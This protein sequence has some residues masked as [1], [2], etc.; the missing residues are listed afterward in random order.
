MSR[1]TDLAALSATE[2]AARI[3]EDGEGEITAAD[4]V[5]AAL[6]RERPWNHLYE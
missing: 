6:E 4:A 5:E 3:R 1:T 2:L